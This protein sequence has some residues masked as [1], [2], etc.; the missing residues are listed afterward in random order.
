MPTSTPSASDTVSGVSAGPCKALEIGC[1]V[2]AGP[3]F[4]SSFTAI[5]ARRS[6]YDWRRHAVSSVADGRGGS[7][8]RANFVLTGVL[9]CLAAHGLAKG[10]K[11]TAGSC[12]VPAL[13]FGVGAGL[14]GVGSVRDR[15]G[16]W[17]P[18][19]TSPAR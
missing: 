17:L 4:V 12:V 14:I 16:G 11:Q 9:Y 3:L 19:V 15:P 2:V 6:G 10:P 7:W 13:I 1:G 8:R 5:G 18:R